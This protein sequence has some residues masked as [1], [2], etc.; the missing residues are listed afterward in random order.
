MADVRSPHDEAQ[1]AGEWPERALLRQA[2]LAQQ[3]HEA[4]EG[5]DI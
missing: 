1:W 3:E 2:R 5:D 4:G